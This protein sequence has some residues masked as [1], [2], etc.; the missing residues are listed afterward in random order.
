MSWLGQRPS[1][2]GGKVALLG[3][4]LAA[5]LPVAATQVCVATVWGSES[6]AGH[7]RGLEH[8]AL[9]PEDPSQ[10]YYVDQESTTVRRVNLNTRETATVLG[11]G[12]RDRN[13]QW[14]SSLANETALTTPSGIAV[15]E[16]GTVF[17][18]LVDLCAVMRGER[19]P[20]LWGLQAIHRRPPSQS[21]DLQPRDRAVDP[22]TNVA[23]VAVGIPF[24]CNVRSTGTVTG[25]LGTA[26]SLAYPVGVGWHPTHGLTVVETWAHRVHLLGHDLRMRHV[27]G[28]GSQGAGADGIAATASDLYAPWH[29]TWAPNG[30]MVICDTFNHRVR[31]VVMA[32]GVIT[33]IAGACGTGVGGEG[34]GWYS[35]ALLWQPALPPWGVLQR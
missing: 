9:H 26:M 28:T 33:T 3:L 24:N 35:F 19:T 32:T 11:T 31:R 23:S 13:A 27:A 25:T 14:V 8:I 34:G 6:H 18:S 7:Y 22:R 30:D 10:L 1:G 5:L 20:R 21:R 4:T 12:I 17:V 29:A 15:S 2:R 16:N